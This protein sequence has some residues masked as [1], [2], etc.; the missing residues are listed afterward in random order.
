MKGVELKT[1]IMWNNVHI[2]MYI[3]INITGPVPLFGGV[4]FADGNYHL[5]VSASSLILLIIKLKVNL[6]V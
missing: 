2:A 5:V 6:A 3:V 4:L 1:G